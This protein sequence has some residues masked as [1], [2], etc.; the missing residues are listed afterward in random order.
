MSENMLD[1]LEEGSINHVNIDV[2]DIHIYKDTTHTELVINTNFLNLFSSIYVAKERGVLIA[3]PHT[4]VFVTSYFFW[5]E[6]RFNYIRIVD[7]V[8]AQ[9]SIFFT[10]IYSFYLN[11]GFEG[12]LLFL[13]LYYVFMMSCH[14]KSIDDENRSLRLHSLLYFIGSACNVYIFTK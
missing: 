7:Y 8:V 2:D 4:A 6:P 9:T 1:Q 13:L 3:L 11:K 14:F 5:K 12:S 10:L